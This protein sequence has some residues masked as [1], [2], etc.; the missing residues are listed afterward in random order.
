M[1]YS[2]VIGI[3]PA[4]H[5]NTKTLRVYSFYRH[6]IPKEGNTWMEVMQEGQYDTLKGIFEIETHKETFPKED[7]VQTLTES[8]NEERKMPIV[9]YYPIFLDE[10]SIEAVKD[11]ANEVF[12]LEHSQCLFFGKNT[13][14]T[15]LSIGVK[16]LFKTVFSDLKCEKEIDTLLSKET[17]IAER[18]RLSMYLYDRI[19]EIYKHDVQIDRHFCSKVNCIYNFCYP[20]IEIKQEQN[21]D[22]ILKNSIKMLVKLSI[23][24]ANKY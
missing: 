18:T 14:S 12:E 5:K 15:I 10:E 6:F 7:S 9:V 16:I 23:E 22:S 17:N 11:P 2:F 19:K 3:C 1:A 21:N 24:I 8:Y 4:I 20:I 13:G